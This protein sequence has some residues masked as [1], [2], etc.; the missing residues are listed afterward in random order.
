[1]TS[2]NNNTKGFIYSNSRRSLPVGW[3]TSLIR[4]NSYGITRPAAT[5]GARPRSRSWT[6]ATTRSA[7]RSSS[8]SS[9]AAATVGPLHSCKGATAY[10]ENEKTEAEEEFGGGGHVRINNER[11]IGQFFSWRNKLVY[12]CLWLI[13]SVGSFEY[14]GIC[15]AMWLPRSYQCGRLLDIEY[16]T[17]IFLIVLRVTALSLSPFLWSLNLIF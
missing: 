9:T 7:T 17:Q 11:I 10:Q 2:W 4:R 1:M 16:N 6:G 12:C 14:L 15:W 3:P 13:Y 8:T 5:T